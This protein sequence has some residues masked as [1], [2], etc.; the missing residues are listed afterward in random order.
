MF[1]K[2]TSTIIAAT[3]FCMIPVQ[4]SVAQGDLRIYEVGG[5]GNDVIWELEPARPL[6]FGS[7]TQEINNAV[8]EFEYGGGIFYAASTNDNTDL[9][10]LEPGTGTLLD[11]VTMNFP[12]SGNVITSMEFVGDTLYAGLAT[13]GGPTDPSSLVTIDTATGAVNLVGDMGFPGP[14][15][16]LAWNGSLYTVNSAATGAAT[17]YSVDTSNGAASAIGSI[18]DQN[19]AEVSLTGLEFGTDGVLYGLGRGPDED[20]LFTIDPANG[21][22]IRNG[23]IVNLGVGRTSSLTTVPE[24][25]AFALLLAGLAMLSLRNRE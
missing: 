5:N 12:G 24:P 19:G 6:A 18:T 9:F 17:L 25:D 3:V 4:V 21:N 10:L 15:G 16:G 11:T 2:T 1:L 7:I 14:T 8:A 22:A 23:A 20:F 13:E